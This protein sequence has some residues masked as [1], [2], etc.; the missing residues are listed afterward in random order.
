MSNIKVLYIEYQRIVCWIG[1][2]SRYRN[3]FVHRKS[4]P[5]KSFPFQH[6]CVGAVELCSSQHK[7]P[8]DTTQTQPNPKRN[9]AT[10]HNPT[11][12]KAAKTEPNRTQHHTSLH[13]AAVKRSVARTSDGSG[14]SHSF[15][16]TRSAVL[17]L[18]TPVYMAN[19]SPVDPTMVLLKISERSLRA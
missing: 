12:T 1:V 7:T 16:L 11:R 10:Q 4:T 6:P 5:G 9:N 18:S 14:V 19:T 2:I 3:G 8:D 17:S 13:H 15:F